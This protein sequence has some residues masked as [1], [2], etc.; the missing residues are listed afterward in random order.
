LGEREEMLM[1]A[2]DLLSSLIDEEALVAAEQP[3][4]SSIPAA[5]AGATRSA[6]PAAQ[7]SATLSH[8]YTADFGDSREVAVQGSTQAAH[9]QPVAQQPSGSLSSSQAEVSSVSG[10]IEVEEDLEA[11]VASPTSSASHSAAG[12]EDTAAGGSLQQEQTHTAAAAA[13]TALADQSK[14]AAEAA[15]GVATTQPAA[16]AGAAG[17][18]S[19]GGSSSA[20]LEAYESSQSGSQLPGG[21]SDL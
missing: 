1:D 18:A 2:S 7:T 15:V 21:W 3:S 10:D 14:T 5:L 20:E 12:G 8:S 11:E 4:S 13:E 6:L 16:V 9:A 17:T 19:S